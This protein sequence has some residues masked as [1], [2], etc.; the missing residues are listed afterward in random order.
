V[1]RLTNKVT[2]FFATAAISALKNL[3]VFQ[4]D[5]DFLP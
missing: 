3:E 5:R 1:G 4:Y 2:I